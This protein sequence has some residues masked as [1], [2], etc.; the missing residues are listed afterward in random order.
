MLETADEISF[1]E[2]SLFFVLLFWQLK[3]SIH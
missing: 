2:A 1:V 3:A